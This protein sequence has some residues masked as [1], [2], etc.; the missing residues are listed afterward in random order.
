MQLASPRLTVQ[1]AAQS[2]GVSESQV[3]ALIRRGDLR[4]VNIGIGRQR[5]RWRITIEDLDRFAAE[6]TA[7]PPAETSRR[8]RAQKQT[9]DFVNYF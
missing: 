7:R 3:L 8:R 1:A 4:A 2:L 9:A 5:A 6:R